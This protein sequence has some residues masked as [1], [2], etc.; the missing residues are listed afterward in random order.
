MTAGFGAIPDELRETANTIADVVGGVLGLAWRGPSGDYGHAGVQRGWAQFVEDM[1]GRV[2][3][4]HA[5][6]EEHGEG[7]K[8]A[9]VQ[10]V[11]RDSEAG[12]AIGGV[13][14]LIDGG[15]AFDNPGM[16]QG[17]WESRIGGGQADGGMVGGG[18]TGPLK[19]AGAGTGGDGTAGIMSPGRSRQLSPQDDISSR[20][21]PGDDNGM[22]F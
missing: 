19:N 14:D 6:A 10:Y 16:V 13:G 7:L 17:G 12:R 8:K 2:E 3:Q 18:W 15:G 11:E 4:L 9:A 22:V 1:R 21:N 5:K 20:L